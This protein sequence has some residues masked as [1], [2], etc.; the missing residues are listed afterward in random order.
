M[1]T[2]VHPVMNLLY[3]IA[4][5]MAERVLDFVKANPG[6]SSNAIIKEMDLNPSPARDCLRNLL[7]RKVI[8]CSAHGASGQTC[9]LSMSAA[10]ARLVR[11]K[12]AGPHSFYPIN[13]V[14][15]KGPRS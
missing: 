1:G 8:M 11:P 12:E 13:R 10:E 7:V 14:M 4:G 3:P 15:P 2:K 5:T 9:S 6:I